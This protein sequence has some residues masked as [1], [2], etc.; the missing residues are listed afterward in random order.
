MLLYIHTECS[1]FSMNTGDRKSRNNPQTCFE[2]N[3]YLHLQQTFHK[4]PVKRSQIHL[5]VSPCFFLSLPLCLLISLSTN[6]NTKE[7]YK[8]KKLKGKRDCK[9]K[10][11]EKWSTSKR[12]KQQTTGLDDCT[13]SKDGLLTLFFPQIFII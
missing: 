12:N 7:N 4:W 13:V 2:T 8:I 5:S 6:V 1:E 10:T 3:F 9:E 11:N